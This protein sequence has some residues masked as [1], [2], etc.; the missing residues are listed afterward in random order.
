[1]VRVTDLTL[2]LMLMALA[3]ALAGGALSF[4]PMPG[5]SFGPKLF[6]NIIAAA[7]AA[8]ALVLALRAAKAKAIKIAVVTPDWWGVPG[9]LGQSADSARQH[10]G[11]HVTG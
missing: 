1:M 2:A 6:P 8:C 7:L 4:P 10:R 5:Q 11:I 9:A 3:I